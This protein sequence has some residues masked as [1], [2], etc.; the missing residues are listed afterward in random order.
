MITENISAICLT[1]ILEN[2]E[3]KFKKCARWGLNHG[4]QNKGKSI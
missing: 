4:K 1:G 2:G 3:Y